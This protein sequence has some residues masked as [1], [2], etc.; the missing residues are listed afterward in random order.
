VQKTVAGLLDVDDGHIALAP[1]TRVDVRGLVGQ[2][3]RLLARSDSLPLDDLYGDPGQGELLPGWYD[4]WVLLEQERLRQLRLH[5]LERAAHELSRRGLYG[6]ALDTAL[7]AVRLEPLRES[8]H[9][10]V[11][12]IHLAEGNVSEAMTHFEAYSG[13]L[14]AELGVPPSAGLTALLRD[15]VPPEMRVTQRRPSSPLQQPTF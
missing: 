10:A 9:A 5:A 2:A 11:M 8:A 3:K 13:L 4:D 15:R 1:G 6:Q 14:R 7:S 12:R